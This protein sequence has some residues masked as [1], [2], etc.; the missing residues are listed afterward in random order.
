[1]YEITLMCFTP[2]ELEIQFCRMYRVKADGILNIKP[3]GK[4]FHSGANT[5]TI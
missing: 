4:G 2:S 3:I 1:M 5:P